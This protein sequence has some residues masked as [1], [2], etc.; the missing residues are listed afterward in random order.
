MVELS[1]IVP[2]L[3]AGVAFGWEDRLRRSPVDA[4]LIVE[5]DG[6]ASEARN[7]G[8][9]ASGADKLV[10]LDDDSV[11]L[12]GYFER[13]ATLLDTYPA[14]TGRIH[15]TGASYLRNLSTQYDQGPEGHFTDTVVGCN[16]AVR[17][18]VIEDIGYFDERLPYGH[19]ETELIDR[20]CDAYDVWYCPDLEVEHPFA[21]SFGEYLEKQYRHGREAVPYY[22]IRGENV[23]RNIVRIAFVPSH[24]TTPT[25]TGT[26]LKT[27]GQVVTL[28]G[29]LQGYVAFLIANDDYGE[30]SRQTE[31][32]D[33]N[34]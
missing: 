23:P 25:L 8:I 11:P 14:V 3:D 10:F 32:Y 21:A 13:V 2:T 22:A 29:L 24:Y 31:G 7:A 1:I 16:M 17:R 15:D 33:Q 30:H 6:S 28:I 12:E 19:E 34:T 4:E 20:L 26:A 27:V 5:D 18:E 9:R